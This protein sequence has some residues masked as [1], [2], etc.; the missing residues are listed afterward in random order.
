MVRNQQLMNVASK[1]IKLQRNV[2]AD[3]ELQF[4]IATKTL[5]NVLDAYQ[6][7]T[8]VQMAEVT[9][10]NDLRDAALL[11]L[12]SQAQITNWISK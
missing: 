1:Q 7:L 5:L 6:E 9:A 3:T 11:Y 8:G 2:V 4:D 10:R 12:V